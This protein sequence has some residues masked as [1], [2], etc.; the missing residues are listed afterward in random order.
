MNSFLAHKTLQ[1]LVYILSSSVLGS[2]IKLKL[3]R[4]LHYHYILGKPTFSNQYSTL[5]NKKN[6]RS[7]F[8]SVV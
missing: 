1:P 3:I 8:L 4:I 7:S 2:N 6:I 5:P